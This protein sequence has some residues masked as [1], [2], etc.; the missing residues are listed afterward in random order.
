LQYSTKVFKIDGNIIHLSDGSRISAKK[1][2]VCCGHHQD[3]LTENS[4]KSFAMETY[5]YPDN[6]GIPA[7]G[8]LIPPASGINH[9]LFW[10]QDGPGMKG[11]KVGYEEGSLKSGPHTTELLNS[12]FK[13]TIISR[14]DCYYST[15]ENRVPIFEMKGDQLFATAL[16]GRGFKFM[17]MYGPII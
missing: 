15:T 2:I 8:V 14:H 7:T 16:N 5:H 10:C 13:A 9:H 12:L 17:P 6:S 4:G 1:I 3:S 11:F